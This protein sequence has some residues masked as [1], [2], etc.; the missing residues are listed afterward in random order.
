MGM[1]SCWSGGK[2]AVQG[3]VVGGRIL[4]Q[5]LG[6][7]IV[8]GRRMG[9]QQK[10]NQRNEEEGL[11]NDVIQIQR[12]LHKLQSEFRLKQLCEVSLFLGIQVIKTNTSY[13]LHQDHYARDLLT[14]AGFTDCKPSE[15]PIRMKPRKQLDEQPYS[16]PTH[17]WKLAGS[18]QYLSITRLDIAFAKNHI[19]QH[20]HKLRNQDYQDLKRL[21]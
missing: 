12:I 13:F 17:F 3:E 11:G 5:S 10:R 21:L 14:L 4:S 6:G 2:I 1:L 8:S 18:L 16:D 9:A 20:M 7:V 19:F 15:T